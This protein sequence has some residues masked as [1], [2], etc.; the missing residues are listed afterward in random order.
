MAA[1]ILQLTRGCFGLGAFGLI[2]FCLAWFFWD[3]GTAVVC[4][5][6]LIIANALVTRPSRRY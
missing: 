3:F 5:V 4:I 1:L 2:M 6:V